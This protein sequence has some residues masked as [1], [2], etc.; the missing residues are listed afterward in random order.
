MSRCIGRIQLQTR[1]CLI[2]AWPRP[3]SVKDLLLWAYPAIARP[4]IWHRKAVHR[5]VKKWAVVVGRT[6]NNYGN[7]WAAN[8]AL[9]RQ[10]KGE[11]TN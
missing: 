9:E 6:G 1:R 11:P 10:I 5:A 8:E 4:T 7:L 3:T 2:A